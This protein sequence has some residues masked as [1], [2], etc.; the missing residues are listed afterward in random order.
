MGGS[1]WQSMLD[2]SFQSSVEMSVSKQL[3]QS[4]CRH[5]TLR[6]VDAVMQMRAWSDPTEPFQSTCAP[7]NVFWIEAAKLHQTRSS[8][9]SRAP[10][11]PLWVGMPGA[12]R[13]VNV[14][15]ASHSSTRSVLWEGVQSIGDQV[16]ECRLKSPTSK[17]GIVESISR[18]V[19]VHKELGSST[20][21]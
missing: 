21:L 8:V 19:R 6:G 10:P 3:V 2:H 13:R 4:S 12:E 15:V 1:S 9:L 7:M 20:L 11:S 14:W 5:L 17:V 18:S 16:H